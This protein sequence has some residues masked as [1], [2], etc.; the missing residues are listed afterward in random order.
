MAPIDF[1]PYT[2]TPILGVRPAEMQALEETAPGTKDALLPYVVLQPWTTARHIENVVAKVEAAVGN[3]PIIVDVTNEVYSGTSRRPVHDVFDLF[4]NSSNGYRSWYA[5]VAN[6]ENYIP[7]V[8]LTDPSQIQNQVPALADLDRG[9]VVRL[10]EAMF[11]FAADIARLF[12]AFEPRSSIYFILDF[13][14]QNHDIL[15]KTAIAINT[16]RNIRAVL[17]GCVISVSASTFP[18]SFVDLDEQDIFERR[19]HQQVVDN[20]GANNTIYCDRASVRAER[21]GGGGGAP[22]P[23]IDN[24]LPARWE[25]FREPE[26]ED[27]EMAYQSAAARAVASAGWTDLGIWGT[28][29]IDQTASGAVNSIRSP[30][31]STAARINIHLHR[32]LGN[33]PNLTEIDWVD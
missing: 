32:Q 19:L 21:Q 10:T 29:I 4:R 26:I 24:A 28:Q 20:L 6:H 3:R 14:R 17:P 5:F 33:N 22:A 16:V 30:K 2:Y 1:A 25:F 8:Q 9:A 15:L 11:P 18:E 13:Q 12:R 31:L 27:R 23:R 7:S